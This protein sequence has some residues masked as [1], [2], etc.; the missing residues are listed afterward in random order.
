MGR[1]ERFLKQFEPTY[2][3]AEKVHRHMEVIQFSDGFRSLVTKKGYVIKELE[4]EE[5]RFD[6]ERNTFDAYKLDR[7]TSQGGTQ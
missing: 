7:M 1:W 2:T 3:E 6:R 5:P 4:K